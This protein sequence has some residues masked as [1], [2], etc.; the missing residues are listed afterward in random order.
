MIINQKY[1]KEYG[2]FPENY[3]LKEVMQYVPIAEEIW[4]KPLI[5]E[6]L[7]EEIE[8]QVEE[9][10]LS[11]E[12]STLL[13]DGQ[14]WRY[15]SM[16]VALEALPMLW[17]NLSQVGLTLGKSDNS[18]S[19]S[20]KDLTLVQ[21]HIRSQ[22]EV[23]KESVKHFICQHQ[24]SFPSADLCSCGCSGCESNSKLIKPNPL[25]ILYSTRRKCSNIR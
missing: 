22:V 4:V 23:L 18:D 11:P 20:L 7:L 19:I 24:E 17:V 15:L 6:D 14:L 1:L 2:I 8:E 13:T 21:Q 16:A 3:D 12:N 5:G 10:D 9:D 25:N